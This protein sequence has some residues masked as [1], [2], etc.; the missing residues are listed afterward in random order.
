[1]DAED[2]EA[3]YFATELLMPREWLIKDVRAMGGID[4]TEDREVAQLAKKYGVSISMMA[5]R[6]MQLANEKGKQ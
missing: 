6:L 3:D 4:L 1:M 2:T 5:V